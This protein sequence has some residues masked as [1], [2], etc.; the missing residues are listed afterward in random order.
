MRKHSL[1]FKLMHWIMAILILSAL[2][3]GLYMVDLKFSMEKVRLINYH[4]WIGFS[5]LLLFIPR[6]LSSFSGYSHLKVE[7]M[8]DKI[9]KL[10]HYLLYLTMFSTPFLGWLMSSAKGFPI[11]YLGY[12]KIPD[13]IGADKDLGHILAL[14]HKFSSYFLIFLLILHIGGAIMRQFVKK[15]PIITNMIK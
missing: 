5:V 2:I 3:L 11:V 9:A 15:D 13:L 12:L 10:V 1:F 7:K 4:K 8:E 14:A 6:V